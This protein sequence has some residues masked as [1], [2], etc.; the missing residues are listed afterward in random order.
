MVDGI[1]EEDI[2]IV[3]K[4]NYEN[5]TRLALNMSDGIILGDK[6]INKNILKHIKSAKKPILEYRPDD[7]YINAYSDFYDQILTMRPDE[8]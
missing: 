7:D 6:Q 1:T 8:A 5:L 4:P 2:S 3:K